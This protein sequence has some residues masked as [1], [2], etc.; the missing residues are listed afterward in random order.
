MAAGLC[1][2]GLGFSLGKAELELRKAIESAS[3]TLHSS[4]GSSRTRASGGL[5]DTAQ[6][7]ALLPDVAETTK[8][9]A[10]LARALKG[11]SPA[12]QA[13]LVSVT[14]FLIAAALAAIAVLGPG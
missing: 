11:L 12:V 8:A 2:I 14:F 6:Q 7:Q 3:K 5:A 1:V 13:F 9:L 4:S 10:E